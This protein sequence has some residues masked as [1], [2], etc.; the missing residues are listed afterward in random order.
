MGGRGGD[1]AGDRAYFWV[2][3]MKIFRHRTINRKAIFQYHA[4]LYHSAQGKQI[5]LQ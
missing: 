1:R 5:I 2:R 4:A 3:D